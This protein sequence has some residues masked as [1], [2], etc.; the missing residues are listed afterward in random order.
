MYGGSVHWKT[1]KYKECK[2]TINFD[3]GPVLGVGLQFKI[4]L[5]ELSKAVVAR[6]KSY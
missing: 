2:H 6:A 5:F 4:L 1:F 3:T